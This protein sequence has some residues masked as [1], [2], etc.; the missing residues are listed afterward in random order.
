MPKK[1]FDKEFKINAVQLVEDGLSI[2]QASRD[3]GIGLSTLQ[4]WVRE[5]KTQGK[6][7][8]PGSG[9]LRQEDEQTRQLRREVEI[10][11]RERDILKKALGIFSST[12]AR[13]TVL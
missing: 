1:K 10:L 11:R 3:L 13:N 9:K 8:F 12:H 2:T 6:K 4:R 7:A 5:I